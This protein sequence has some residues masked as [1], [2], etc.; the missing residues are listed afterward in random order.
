MAETEAWIPQAAQLCQPLPSSPLYSTPAFLFVIALP[1]LIYALV[2]LSPK[3]WWG[4][5]GKNSLPLFA[6]VGIFGKVLQ[7][8]TMV[9]WLWSSQP[10]GL[11]FRQ[12]LALWQVL[13]AAALIGYGQA[14]NLGT[15]RALGL[16]GVYYGCRLGRSVPWVKG[17]PFNAISHPQYV[18][19]T[20]TIWGALAL[21]HTAAPMPLSF[22][23]GIYWTCMYIMSGYIEDTL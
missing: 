23:I 6:S 3:V 7:F 16:A 22:F 10:T 11:C 15:Y 18:G 19:S 2:W 9:L 4:T 20:M 13:L 21:F 14:L 8:S 12:P 5:F 1:H 17:W